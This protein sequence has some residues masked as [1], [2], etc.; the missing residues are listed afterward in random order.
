MNKQF[1]Y[2]LVKNERKTR[3]KYKQLSKK[4]SMTKVQ[5]N[6]KQLIMLS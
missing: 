6:V 2:K 1:A 5:R 4:D 3:Q